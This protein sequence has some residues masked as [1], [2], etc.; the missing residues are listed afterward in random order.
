M[1][2]SQVPLANPSPL[3]DSQ[4]KIEP[5]FYSFLKTKFRALYL[6][7]YIPVNF[8]YVVVQSSDIKYFYT[9]LQRGYLSIKIYIYV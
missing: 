2:Q 3:L 5:S 4:K 1:A 9:S 7:V 6:C 8:S